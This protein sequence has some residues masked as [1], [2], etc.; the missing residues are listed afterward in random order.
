MEILEKDFGWRGKGKDE[1]ISDEEWQ[2]HVWSMCNLFL[3]INEWMMLVLKQNGCF[4]R[5]Q[6]GYKVM[7][8]KVSRGKR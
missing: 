8:Q 1:V 4:F 3:M 6:L 7:P 5:S 2:M